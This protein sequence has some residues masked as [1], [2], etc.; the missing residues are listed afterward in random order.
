VRLG[1]LYDLKLLI[2]AHPGVLAPALGR[3]RAVGLE[4]AVIA[5]THLA[6]TEIGAAED[7]AERPSPDRLSRLALPLLSLDRGPDPR[8]ESL[9]NVACTAM[10]CDSPRRAAA[11]LAKKVGRDL[12]ARRLRAG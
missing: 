11:H 10:L 12:P 1:W 3:A 5:A 4:R 9:L 2:R 8:T 7:E 6:S